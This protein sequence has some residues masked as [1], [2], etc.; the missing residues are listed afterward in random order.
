MSD[1]IAFRECGECAAKPGAPDLCADCLRRRDAAVR[2]A[3]RPR[4]FPYPS[5]TLGGFLISRPRVAIR[6]CASGGAEIRLTYDVTDVETGKPW[7]IH[8][9]ERWPD[10]IPA[11]EWRQIVRAFLR[12]VIEHEIDEWL[13]IDGVREAPKEGHHNER[14]TGPAIAPGDPARLGRE[15]ADLAAALPEDTRIALVRRLDALVA[16]AESR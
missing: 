3:R 2:E 9:V 1:A 7:Q 10:W 4:A 8:S 6:E 13:T 12:T 11:D 14:A 5:I 15:I 16:H